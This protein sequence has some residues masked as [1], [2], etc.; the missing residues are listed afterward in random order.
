MATSARNA[1]RWENNAPHQTHTYQPITLLEVLS[2]AGFRARQR[3]IALR[4]IRSRFTRRRDILRA[5]LLQYL[6]CAAR[7]IGVVAVHRVLNAFLSTSSLVSLSY[8]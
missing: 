2:S 8:V 3:F 6:L 5:G 4:K 7:P 1:A